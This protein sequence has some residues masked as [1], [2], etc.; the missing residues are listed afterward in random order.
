VIEHRLTKPV[1]P[2]TNGRVERFNG[3]IADDLRSYRFQV[4]DFLLKAMLAQQ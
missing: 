1:T 2:R 4:P 3:R